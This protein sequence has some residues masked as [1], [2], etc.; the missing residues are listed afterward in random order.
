MSGTF[1]VSGTNAVNFTA[2]T[3]G[4]VGSGAYTMAALVQ[5]AAGNNSAGFITALASSTVTR[6]LFEDV[7]KLFGVND[8]SA[9]FGSITQGSWYLVAQT[10]ASGSNTYRHHL[11]AYASD[12]S[13]TMSH[14]VSTSSANQ[15]DGSTTTVLRLGSASVKANG[16]I[17]VGAWW[18]RVLSDAELDSMKSNLLTAWKNVSG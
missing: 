9:G 17:A 14:G 12:G 15:G 8:F 11:W 3:A 18:A 4:A 2:G 5:P 10:K 1:S 16:L 13:G 6:D 7:N